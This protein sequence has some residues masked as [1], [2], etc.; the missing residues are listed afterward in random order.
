[1]GWPQLGAIRLQKMHGVWVFVK[2]LIARWI[3]VQAVFTGKVKIVFFLL[4]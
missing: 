1:M 3:K 4:L 2:T